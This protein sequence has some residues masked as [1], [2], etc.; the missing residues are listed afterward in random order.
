MKKTCLVLSV[1]LILTAL[2]ASGCTGREPGREVHTLYPGGGTYAP[3]T[4]YVTLPAETVIVT[5][6]VTVTGEPETAGVTEPEQTSSPSETAL[7]ETGET[8]LPVT[9]VSWEMAENPINLDG[10]GKSRAELI[11]PKLSGMI[12]TALEEKINTLFG[13][14]T[15]VDFTTNELC[16]DHMEKVLAGITVNYRITECTVTL[17]KESMISVMWKAEYTTS[18]SEEKTCLAFAHTV[19][20]STGKE[21]KAKDVFSDF[22][23]ILDRI[24]SGRIPRTGASEDFDSKNDLQQ[25]VSNY[26]TR[27]AYSFYPPVCFTEDSVIVILQSEGKTGGWAEYTAKTSDVGGFMKII[28]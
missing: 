19:N 18:D 22:A 11:Y 26:K 13:Q 28:P 25:L 12:N 24:S 5:V 4:I 16:K 27:L 21:V 6:P 8:T 17:F 14:I 23:S 2:A 9:V 20:L 7:T 15:E 3:Q 10:A 1:L